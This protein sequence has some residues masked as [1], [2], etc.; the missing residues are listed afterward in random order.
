MYGIACVMVHYTLYILGLY[1]TKNSTRIINL[2]VLLMECGACEWDSKEV[3]IMMESMTE[4]T[5]ECENMKWPQL[6]V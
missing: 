3:C 4:K 6:Q 2:G 1:F 5:V